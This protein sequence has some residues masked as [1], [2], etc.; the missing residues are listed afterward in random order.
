[1]T[2]VILP[3]TLLV[4]PWPMRTTEWSIPQYFTDVTLASDDDWAEPPLSLCW[5]HSGLWVWL[6]SVSHFTLLVSPWTLRMTVLS[7][8]LSLL[9]STWPMRMAELSLPPHFTG[10]TSTT[11][12]EWGQTHF[13]DDPLA[14]KDDW[15]QNQ[16]LTLLM[17]PWPLRMND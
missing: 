9:V 2:E 4:S 15:V 5:F 12:D 10:V 13:S 8:P 7:L 11:E 14:Y 6:I 3:L 1:M 16:P 17:S